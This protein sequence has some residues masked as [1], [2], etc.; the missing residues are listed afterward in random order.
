MAARTGQEADGGAIVS[1]QDLRIHFPVGRRATLKA[2]D[3]VSF[4]VLPGEVF[5]I[6]GES[7]SGKSTLGRAI[8][9]LRKPTSGTILHEG[10]DFNALS[11]RELRTVRRGYQIVFQDPEGA[12][13][14]RMTVLQSVREP[15]DIEGMG[16]AVEREAMARK[17]LEQVGL[18]PDF[19]GR[20]PHELSGGQKQR[21]NIARVLTTRPKLIVC[22]EAVAALDVSI[23]AEVINLFSQ[24]Q[25]DLGLTYVFI[26]HDLNVVAH[27]SHRIA[28]MYLGGIV[29]IGSVE[30]V[31]ASPLHPY[32]RALLQ[33]RPTPVPA[34]M[35]ERRK[36]ALSGE[37]PSAMAPPSGCHFRT[38]CPQAVAKCEAVAP[39]WDNIEPGRWAAC[40]FA[41]D[42]VRVKNNE[43]TGSRSHAEN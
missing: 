41:R 13:D 3:G 9:A 10:I 23:Q 29:E 36:P 15:L 16:S 14:P 40:H 7:G 19:A 22:D 2:V 34:S 24:L 28:V 6:I 21:V 12:L 32:T 26:S 20:Y 5:G 4:D 30:E 1:V 8:V 35:R 11:K 39:L 33:S 18:G 43:A 38:R 17:C 31:V 37:I 27:I 25:R 42:S